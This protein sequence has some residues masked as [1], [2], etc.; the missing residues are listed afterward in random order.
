MNTFSY[1]LQEVWR[2][3]PHLVLISI[4]VLVIGLMAKMKLFTKANKNLWS[5]FVPI[6][7]LISIMEMVGRPRR[8]WIYMCIPI[9]N[10]YF[11]FVLIL[12][13]AKSF[14]KTSRT[15]QILALVFNLF[16]LLNLALSF[17]EEYAGPVHKEVVKQS[18]APLL[19]PI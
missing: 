2:N 11:G 6:W 15:Q 3:Q 7:D 12:E 18:D 13:I 8:Q 10:I 4:F 19:N 5:A 9:F 1:V 16:Y 14:G 17:E